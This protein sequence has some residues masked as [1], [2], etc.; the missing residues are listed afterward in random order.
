LGLRAI[1]RRRSGNFFRRGDGAQ[2]PLSLLHPLEYASPHVRNS[3]MLSKPDYL[4]NF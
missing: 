4:N 3:R 2:P 1:P